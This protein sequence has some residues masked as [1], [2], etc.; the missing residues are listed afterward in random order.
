MEI[1]Q[2]K[3]KIELPHD[4]AIPLLDIYSEKMKTLIL[5]VKSLGM[6]LLMTNVINN[7]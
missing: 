7:C 2:K 4:L 3:L 1:P 6:T 5:N